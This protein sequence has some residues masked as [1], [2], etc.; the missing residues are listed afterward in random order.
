VLAAQHD[1]ELQVLDD[2]VELGRRRDELV[3]H[4]ALVTLLGHLDEDADLL[5]RGLGLLDR[6]DA[7]AEP[8]QLGDDLLG[9]LL[10]VPEVR[11]ALKGL[12]LD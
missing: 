6:L 11:I 2:L 3:D 10:V 12:D 4:V 5:E 9:L 8:L 1:L 7:G